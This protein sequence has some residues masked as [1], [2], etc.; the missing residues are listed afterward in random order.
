MFVY[1]LAP[2]AGSGLLLILSAPLAWR[3]GG[4]GL[5]NRLVPLAVL[6]AGFVLATLPWLLALLIGLDGQVEPLRGFVGA[7]DITPLAL[8]I[9]LPRSSAWLAVLGLGLSALLAVRLGWQAD[10]IP[11]GP[12]AG[13]SL[14]LLLLTRE[15]GRIAHHGAAPGAQPGPR[16]PPGLR[17]G[18]GHLGRHLAGP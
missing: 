10:W 11:A 18:R 14:A 12:L 3:G 7:L 16:R 15:P 8:P 4:E 1:L 2:I 5:V 17:P 6:A 9:E 13:F